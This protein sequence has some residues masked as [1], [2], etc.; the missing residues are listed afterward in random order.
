MDKKM[1]TVRL[2]VEDFPVECNVEYEDESFDILFEDTDEWHSFELKNGDLYDIHLLLENEES[3][4]YEILIYT[5]HK[6]YENQRN[7]LVLEMLEVDTS[8]E[9]QQLVTLLIEGDVLGDK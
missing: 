2:N 5:V 3:D 4:D 6:V 9:G 8:N 7:G 1:F